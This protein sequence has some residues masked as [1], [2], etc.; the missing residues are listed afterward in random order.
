MN[1]EGWLMTCN[2]AS[3]CVENFNY[4]QG[5]QLLKSKSRVTLK[6]KFRK[7]LIA[8]SSRDGKNKNKLI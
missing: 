6:K 4:K 7:A 1:F 2:L 5:Y 3:L 8:A